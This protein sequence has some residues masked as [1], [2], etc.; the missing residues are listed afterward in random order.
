MSVGPQISYIETYETELIPVQEHFSL[1]HSLVGC[2]RKLHNE[3]LHNLHSSS[4]IIGMVLS[5]KVRLVRRETL[6]FTSGKARRKGTT[7]KTKT[8][9]GG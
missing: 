1:L 3:E 8:Q 5:R 4:N 2:C 6:Q 7:I 9:I